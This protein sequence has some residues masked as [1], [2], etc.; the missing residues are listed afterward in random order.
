MPALPKMPTWGFSKNVQV[1]PQHLNHAIPYVH[2]QTEN[3]TKL[4]YE[5]SFIHRLPPE[6][7]EMVWR[8]FLLTIVEDQADYTFKQPDPARTQA[9]LQVLLTS[10]LMFVELSI[11]L[12][13]KIK[14]VVHGSPYTPANFELRIARL[15]LPTRDY[16]TRVIFTG[17]YEGRLEHLLC[18]CIIS[19]SNL[20]Y[21][22]FYQSKDVAK[23]LGEGVWLT[24][25]PCPDQLP[26]W[27]APRFWSERKLPQGLVRRGRWAHEV[28][29]LWKLR[30]LPFRFVHNL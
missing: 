29:F 27:G 25:Q 14:F 21:V 17:T 7:R 4:N 24:D 5:D 16:L 6:L 13:E 9:N 1:Q 26:G 28:T 19:F 20:R 15:S 23:L 3:V 12:Y 11:R 22:L 2:P 18:R 30:K 10:R 8:E